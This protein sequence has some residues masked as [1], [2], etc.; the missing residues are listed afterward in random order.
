M[1][2]A[3]FRPRFNVGHLASYV[4]WALMLANGYGWWAAG[5]L[6]VGC[7]VSS[8]LETRP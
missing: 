1:M 5:T 6:F 8:L 3:L 4:A 2:R 7:T